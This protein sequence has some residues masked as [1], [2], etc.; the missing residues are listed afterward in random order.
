MS[1]LH[2]EPWLHWPAWDCMIGPR[3]DVGLIVFQILMRS[4]VPT[5]GKMKLVLVWFQN[6]SLFQSSRNN[7]VTKFMLKLC[8]FS[9]FIFHSLGF[10]GA[11]LQHGLRGRQF[12]LC[13]QHVPV[14]RN[15]EESVFL[16]FETPLCS[17]LCVVAFV[18]S[19]KVAPICKQGW[20][21]FMHSVIA[22]MLFESSLGW[23]GGVRFPKNT[24]SSL[25]LASLNIHLDSFARIKW[26]SPPDAFRL[27][28]EILHNDDQCLEAAQCKWFGSC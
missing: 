20:S 7:A 11:G 13:H 25:S 27:Q 14:S 18:S 1:I 19:Q 8:H 15:G 24:S 23:L 17:V 21:N 6:T 9:S 26:A 22:A 3:L 16:G 28:N 10:F 5:Q 12:V 4:Q 2:G